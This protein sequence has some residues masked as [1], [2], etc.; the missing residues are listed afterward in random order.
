MAVASKKKKTSKKTTR[1]ERIGK[2]LTFE[3][4]WAGLMELR[5]ERKETDRQIKETARQISKL[6]NRFGELAEHLVLPGIK[7]RFRELNYN[8]ERVY[9]DLVITDSSRQCLAEID[10]MLENGDTV[11]AVEVKAKPDKSDI[12]QHIKRIEVLRRHADA[13]NDKRKFQGT[14]AGAI[15]PKETLDYI[16]KAGLYAIEQ[17]GDT[18]RIN[19]PPNFKPREW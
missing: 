13:H 10:I 2:G 11:M 15:M 14:I 7:E 5:E 19:I 17:A 4:V 3:K 16:H 18:M 1:A 9:Q 8:F 12:D 6:G